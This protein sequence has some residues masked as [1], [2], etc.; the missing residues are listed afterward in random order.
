VGRTQ[1]PIH[2]T[3]NKYSTVKGDCSRFAKKIPMRQI[4]RFKMRDETSRGITGGTTCG[5]R[6][7]KRRPRKDP[8]SRQKAIDGGTI[9]GGRA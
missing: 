6:L 9:G 5:E 3:E 2:L 1:F 7:Q 8:M 4:N